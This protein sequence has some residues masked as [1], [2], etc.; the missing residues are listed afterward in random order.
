MPTQPRTPSPKEIQELANAGTGE[1]RGYGESV[2]VSEPEEVLEKFGGFF[3]VD[4]LDALEGVAK[5][6]RRNKL[7]KTT[8]I[9]LMR[10][11]LKSF[12]ID[13]A[14]D[15]PIAQV[16]KFEAIVNKVNKK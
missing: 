5:F 3:S 15:N 11:A 7:S 1:G 12:L 14:D 9:A 2:E 8:R 6:R 13:I 10:I 4:D 16:Q